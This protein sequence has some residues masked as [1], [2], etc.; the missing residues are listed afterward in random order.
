VIDAHLQQ[1]CTHPVSH[2]FCSSAR[3]LAWRWLT[4]LL[5]I[6]S[7]FGLESRFDS[8]SASCSSVLC[9]VVPITVVSTA[10][11][12]VPKTTTLGEIA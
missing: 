8:P 10:L 7:Y 2:F 3:L 4:A 5:M 11:N 9:R 12:L 1:A 6:Y